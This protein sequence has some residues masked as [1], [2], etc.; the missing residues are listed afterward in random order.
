[1][2]CQYEAAAHDPTRHCA[3]DGL[4][5]LGADSGNRSPQIM[6]YVV[7][8]GADGET[9]IA[10]CG[11]HRHAVF[12]CIEA[13]PGRSKFVNDRNAERVSFLRMIDGDNGDALGRLVCD[14]AHSN[15]PLRI[16]EAH[17]ARENRWTALFGVGDQSALM[18]AALMMSAK[19]AESS[20]TIC[21]ISSGVS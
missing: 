17:G 3:D 19:V 11:Q 18:F 21:A 6:R 4:F 13:P 10:G 2:I 20:R 7:E 9:L 16:A 12:A 5:D 15:S 1:M 14:D 8:V